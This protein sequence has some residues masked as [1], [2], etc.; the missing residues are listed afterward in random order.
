MGKSITIP[1]R[2][3]GGALNKRAMLQTVCCHKTFFYQKITLF[4][5]LPSLLSTQWCRFQNGLLRWRTIYLDHHQLQRTT[6]GLQSTPLHINVNVEAGLGHDTPE[7]A[8]KTGKEKAKWL[9][10]C[11][12]NFPKP[13]RH[14]KALCSN[15][16]MKKR[17]WTDIENDTNERAHVHCN[18]THPTNYYEN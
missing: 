13:V 15:V 6:Q 16:S 17:T 11:K 9:L 3:L 10:K 5:Q 18:T 1:K 14:R 2:Q 8:Q 4:L 12:D 7:P